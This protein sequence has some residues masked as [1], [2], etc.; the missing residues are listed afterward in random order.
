MTSLLENPASKKEIT[1]QRLQAALCHGMKVDGKE[2][3]GHS[4]K[5]HLHSVQEGSRQKGRALQSWQLLQLILAKIIEEDARVACKQQQNMQCP[6][7]APTSK[8]TTIVDPY[9]ILII[10]KMN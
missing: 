7:H 1:Q 2:Q 6:K 5:Y 10:M 8:A 4:A 3:V 9:T